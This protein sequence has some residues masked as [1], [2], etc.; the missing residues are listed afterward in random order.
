VTIR[1][2]LTQGQHPLGKTEITLRDSARTSIGGGHRRRPHEQDLLRATFNTTH[3]LVVGCDANGIITSM[4]PAMRRFTGL[5]SDGPLPAA[6]AQLQTAC[7]A[8]GKSAAGEHA[9]LT[10]CLAGEALLPDLEVSLESATG[11]RRTMV[12]S[13]ERL[14]TSDGVLLGAIEVLRDITDQRDAEA[15]VPSQ[16]G[17]DALTHLP[18]RAR[19]V[20]HVKIALRRASRHHRSTA[21][22]ALNLDDYSLMSNRLGKDGGRQVLAEVARRLT[23]ALRPHDS[24]A[25]G[26]DTATRLGGDQFLL[27]C[28]DIADSEA[29][30]SVA[31]RVAEALRVPMRIGGAVLTITAGV[32]ITLTAD[33]HHDPE[34]LIFEAEMAMHVAKRRGAGRHQLFVP[35]MGAQLQS[36]MDNADA[37]REALAK[38]EFRVVYQPKVSLLTDRIIGVE[39]LLRWD[40]PIRGVIP[41]LDFIPLAEATGL[42]VPIGRWVLEQVCRDAKRWSTVLAG[43]LPLSIAVNVS[44]RQFEA[45][46]AETFGTIMAEA[47]IDPTILCVEVTE[48]MVMHDAELAIGTLRKLKSLGMRISIDDFGT[49]FSS[50]AYLKRFPLDELK[51]DKSFVDGIGIDPDS[52]AIVAAVM[53]MA[54]ALDL[55]VV[56]E[57]V[58]TADQLNR[59][60]TLGCDEVQGYY[61]ARPSTPDAI[62]ALLAG[63]V[64][65][66]CAWH[67]GTPATASTAAVRKILVVDDAPDVRQLLRS[68]LA[69]VGFE[70]WEAGSGEEA[71]A[72]ARKLRPDCVVLDINLPGISGLEVCRILRED[73]A[74][75]HTTIVML[76]VDAEPAE[77]I[78]A[79]TVNADDYMVK[80]FSPRD[81]VSRV[82]ASMRRRTA[83]LAD[84][85][86]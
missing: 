37:L 81:I 10:R 59:L 6:C 9:L 39:A 32:G 31:L 77:K 56:A 54:H 85:S 29:A 75:E 51:I 83:M 15:L 69:A 3:D 53:G 13:G 61:F 22:L 60:R 58:E 11:F 2:Q 24:V 5:T 7:T 1:P 8:N 86:R 82:T 73:L 20:R 65:G 26:V 78:E 47:G 67:G 35:E 46:L 52:T 70:V 76:S 72:E 44:P 17:H 55:H 74:N 57:G 79:F 71:I 63:C 25:S 14:V 41:P 38:G 43:G 27:L 66:T 48:S 36:R 49:G 12:A 42:I 64:A 18:N 16:A 34:A 68:S 19:F 33:P 80:P 62:D 21:V 50:L 28:E 84:R 40:D 45:G 30:E 4:N 23:A